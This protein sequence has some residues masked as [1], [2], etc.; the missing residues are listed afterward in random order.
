[1]QAVLQ[2]SPTS[3]NPL[4]EIVRGAGSSGAI[5]LLKKQCDQ[6]SWH[7]KEHVPLATGGFKNEKIRV[8]EG[9]CIAQGKTAISG[10]FKS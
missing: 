6:D 1:M 10:K 4:V 3:A 8:A 5:N 7:K 2:H 9:R